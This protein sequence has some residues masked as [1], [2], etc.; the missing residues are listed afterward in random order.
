MVEKNEDGVR[1]ALKVC[2]CENEGQDY[3]HGRKIRV[4]NKTK[5]GDW[6]CTVCKSEK[7]RKVG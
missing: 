5:D 2:T 7:S 1:T 6:R 4:H 3:L